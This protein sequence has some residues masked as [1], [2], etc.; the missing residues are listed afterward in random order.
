[1]DYGTEAEEADCVRRLHSVTK[2]MAALAD[3]MRNLAAARRDVIRTLVSQ[4]GWT[5]RGVAAE[6]GITE[7]AVCKVLRKKVKKHDDE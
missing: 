3:Y 6:L 5:Q 1:M 4:F 2:D 7:Q